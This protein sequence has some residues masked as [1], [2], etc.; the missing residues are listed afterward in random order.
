[1]PLSPDDEAR[2]DAWVTEQ[3][4]KPWPLTSAQLDVIRRALGGPDDGEAHPRRCGPGDADGQPHAA[5]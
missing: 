2:I 4:S 3:L 1:M 5:H